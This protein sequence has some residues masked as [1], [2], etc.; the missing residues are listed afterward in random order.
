MERVVVVVQKME[1]I[2][3]LQKLMSAKITKVGK[4]QGKPTTP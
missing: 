2:R 3:T 4:Q 1:E